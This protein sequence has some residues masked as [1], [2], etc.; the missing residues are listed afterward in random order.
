MKRILTLSLIL[1]L[2]STFSFAQI[3]IEKR[4]YNKG[5]YISVNHKKNLR[6]EKA[7]AD[8]TAVPEKMIPQKRNSATEEKTSAELQTVTEVKNIPAAFENK[9]QKKRSVKPASEKVKSVAAPVAKEVK[10]LVTAPVKMQQS[11]ARKTISKTSAKADPGDNFLSYMG[12]SLADAF[13]FVLVALAVL[14]LIVYL[15]SLVLNPGAM[16]VIG[17]ILW[18]VFEILENC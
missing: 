15:L 17:A 18:V 13:L 9:I 10:S 2:I 14:G 16:T 8:E 6:E 1:S 12:K 3:R 11:F 7:E 5:W 4:H